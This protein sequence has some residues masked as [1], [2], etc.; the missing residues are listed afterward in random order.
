MSDIKLHVRNAEDGQQHVIDC[1]PDIKAAD[2]IAE[3]ID[4]LH[5]PPASWVLD[6][7]ECAATLDPDASLVSNGVANGHH[8]RLRR[9]GHDLQ[10][11]PRKEPLIEKPPTKKVKE[12]ESE[13]YIA[14][15]P[16]KDLPK[17]DGRPLWQWLT[18][19]VALIVVVLLIAALGYR[20]VTAPRATVTLNPA[21]AEVLVSQHARFSAVVK[22][23]K[24]QDIRWHLNPELGTITPEGVYTAPPMAEPGQTVAITAASVA[25]PSKSATAKIT[26]R[27]NVQVE[28]GPAPTTV[29]PSQKIQFVAT[30][31]GSTNGA[32]RWSLSPEVGTIAPDGTFTAPATVRSPNAITV[33]ATSE[34]DQ[35]KSATVTISVQPVVVVQVLVSPVHAALTN[36]GQM[37][38]RA[39]VSGSPNQRVV[40]SASEGSI[41]ANGAY[42]APLSIEPGA[43]AVITARSVADHTKIGRAVVD[44]RAMIAVAISPPSAQLGASKRQQ[45]FTALITGTTNS[46]V[47]WSASA[48]TIAANGLLT[49]EPTKVP[50]SIRV[51]ATSEADPTKEAVANVFVAPLPAKPQI[52]EVVPHNETGGLILWSGFL[53][54][55]GELKIEGFQASTGQLLRGG[56]PGV[57]ISINVQPLELVGVQEAPGPSNNWKRL[58]LRSKKKIHA[59]I[60]IEWKTI[61]VR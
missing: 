57:P 4:G 54:A 36:S 53:E 24:N 9:N 42:T 35:A 1:P 50:Q 12:E 44:L 5:L 59:V 7:E 18:A 6:D 61:T 58:V 27:A 17:D 3:L 33:T 37:I 28:I 51:T 52:T 39:S 15:P 29:S 43:R 8:L 30:V 16:T 25:D 46:T 49:V 22:G 11:P 21:E 38:F 13:E 45:Q 47:R 41:T 32:V 10:K 56:I 23:S 14:E 60:S 40:W 48:G 31:T 55:G 20:V 19:S 34:A 2:F 26:L